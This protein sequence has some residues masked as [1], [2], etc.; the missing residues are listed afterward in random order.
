MFLF[1]YYFFWGGWNHSAFMFMFF[2]SL[3][4]GWNGITEVRLV[5]AETARARANPGKLFAA[6]T[7]R[8]GGACFDCTGTPGWTLNV[9]YPHPKWVSALKNMGFVSPCHVDPI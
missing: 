9:A 1:Y 7:T 5:P 4:E 6:R 8:S 2:V 3:G